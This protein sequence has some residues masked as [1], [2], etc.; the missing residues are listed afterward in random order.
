M[1]RIPILKVGKALLV[2]VQVDMHDR[3]A[4]ALEEDL[5]ARIVAA[6]AR[7]VLID[8]SGLDIVDSFHGQNARQHRGGFADARRRNGRRRH[9]AGGRHHARRAWPR[10]QRGSHRAQ[11][12][13]GDG[14]S[15]A[16][17][18]GRRTRRPGAPSASP[19]LGRTT[20][21]TPG[22][23]GAWAKT[24][25]CWWSTGWATA[26]W[27]PTRPEPRPGPTSPA[28]DAPTPGRSSGFT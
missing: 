12:R 18:R 16:A 17:D 9:A 4:T 19:S 1:D 15:G 24:C 11:C 10:T 5:S 22:A 23:S 14:A 7:G 28:R 8:I 3:L 27:P 13:K 25:P 20:A 21:A 26:R 6:G 2:T